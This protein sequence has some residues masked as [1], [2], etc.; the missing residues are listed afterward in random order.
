MKKLCFLS[1]IVLAFTAFLPA[2]VFAGG[3]FKSINSQTPHRLMMKVADGITYP[4]PPPSGTVRPEFNQ[5]NVQAEVD[6]QLRER[7]DAATKNGTKSLTAERAYAVGWGFITDNFV[8]IDRNR[9]GTASLD[10][11]SAYL[12]GRSAVSI[13]R[14]ASSA[15]HIVE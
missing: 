3:L 10:E 9:S 2:T 1:F 15:V 13:Q 11:I 12:D 6:L 14:K 7:Y 8:L 5:E 4:P